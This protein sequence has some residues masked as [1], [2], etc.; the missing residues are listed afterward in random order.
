[1][2]NSAATGKMFMKPDV[3]GLSKICRKNETR[4]CK[5][6]WGKFGTCLKPDIMKE[7]KGEIY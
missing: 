3:V 7:M 1:M 2:N 4:L 5:G 6:D